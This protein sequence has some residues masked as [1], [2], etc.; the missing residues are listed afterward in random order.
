MAKK[1]SKGYTAREAEIM[2]ALWRLG[3]ATAERIRLELPHRPHDSTVRTI[4]RILE[5]KG[6]VRRDTRDRVHVYRAVAD[7]ARAQSRA[8]AEVLGRFF[9]GSAEELVLRLV[10]DEHL[11]AEQLQ[12][13]R[14]SR[15]EKPHQ[16]RQKR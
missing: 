11:T 16:K 14:E 5:S 1:S 7:R 3:N 2:E 12:V 4:L 10:E 8:L 9:G 15:K 6:K 13:L